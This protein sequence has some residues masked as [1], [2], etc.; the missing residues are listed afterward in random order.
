MGV[1]IH[2]QF[3]QGT[4]EDNYHLMCPV[5]A[6]T[7]NYTISADAEEIS[8]N[9]LLQDFKEKHSHADVST[10]K[11]KFEMVSNDNLVL[12]KSSILQG[13]A[14]IATNHKVVVT[15]IAPPVSDPIGTGSYFFSCKHCKGF[16]CCPDST[17][18]KVISDTLEDFCKQHIHEEEPSLDNDKITYI[19][20]KA[21]YMPSPSLKNPVKFKG[22]KSWDSWDSDYNVPVTLMGKIN[23]KSGVQTVTAV[24]A[25]TLKWIAKESDFNVD[26]QVMLY[27]TRYRFYCTKCNDEFEIT[28]EE[29]LSIDNQG[30]YDGRSLEFLNVHK[31]GLMVKELPEGRKFR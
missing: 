10:P 1:S 27:P 8:V 17:E 11:P 26:L 7:T 25:A 22:L 16:F 9:F 28:K 15:K 31:H 3:N 4:W 6:A 18:Y 24:S 23:T 5:C 14:T 19:T 30:V 20:Y 21:K 12:T 29:V 2:K 13:F